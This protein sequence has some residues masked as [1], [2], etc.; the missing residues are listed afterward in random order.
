LYIAKMNSSFEKDSWS[1]KHQ[2]DDWV[3]IV[4]IICI[5]YGDLN[6][7]ARNTQLKGVSDVSKCVTMNQMIWK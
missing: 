1:K 3:G 7:R 4:I 2:I 6:Y 5:S